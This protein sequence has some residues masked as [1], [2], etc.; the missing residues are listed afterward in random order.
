MD[1]SSFRVYL[2][3]FDPED[4]NTTRPWREDEEILKNTVG[5]KY[6]VSHEYERKWINDAIFDK[7]SIKLAICLKE[8][9]EHIGNVYLNKI[10]HVNKN[11]RFG[12]L[13]G[14]KNLWDQGVCSEAA[15]L[16]L[17]HAFYDLGMVRVTSKQLVTNKKSRLRQECGF[18]LEGVLRKAVF[19]NGEYCDVNLLAIIR[20]DFDNLVKSK[21]WESQ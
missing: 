17:N 9:K 11:C 13:I 7:S 10:D 8:T 5:R 20:E 4:Y 6:F 19:K 2:R 14:D 18:K 12:I 1:F 16:M 3:A 15:L 21:D